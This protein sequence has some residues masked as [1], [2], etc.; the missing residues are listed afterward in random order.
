MG[1]V[2]TAPQTLGELLHRVG[3]VGQGVLKVVRRVPQLVHCGLVDIGGPHRI[4]NIAGESLGLLIQGRENVVE[5]EPVDVVLKGLP[6]LAQLVDLRRELDELIR[7][8]VHRTSLH[9]EPVP[10]GQ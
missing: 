9:Y 4:V 8:G 7:R 6:P 2:D 10:V 5:I 3:G 1:R